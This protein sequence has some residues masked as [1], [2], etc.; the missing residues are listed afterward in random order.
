VNAALPS[1]R[2]SQP[3]SREWYARQKS[4]ERI[5]LI[6]LLVIAPLIRRGSLRFGKTIS[7]GA[8]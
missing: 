2:D 3:K 7:W 4:R 1:T 6:G 8:R 5:R